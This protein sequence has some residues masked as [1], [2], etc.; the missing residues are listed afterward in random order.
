MNVFLT[1]ITY[2]PIE[3][4]ISHMHL[5]L[6]M[7]SDKLTLD[8]RQSINKLKSDLREHERIELYSFE[9]R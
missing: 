4:L 3:S 8:S 9:T 1:A 7:T 5:E 2:L 6:A